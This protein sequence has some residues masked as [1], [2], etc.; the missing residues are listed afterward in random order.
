[1]AQNYDNIKNF[2][3]LNE[4]RKNGTRIFTDSLRE[5]AD[6]NGFF[7]KV[8]P[9]GFKNLSGLNQYEIICY[10]PV[11]TNSKARSRTSSLPF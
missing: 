10:F 5:N 11:L 7:L 1:M 8:N 4:M 2:P 9:T 6:K 3:N